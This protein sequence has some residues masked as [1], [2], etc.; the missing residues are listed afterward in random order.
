MR[1]I[2]VL[3]VPPCPEGSD[4]TLFSHLS[5]TNSYETNPA[6]GAPAVG[7]SC[8]VDRMLGES[9]RGGRGASRC[10]GRDCRP[11]RR[12]AGADPFDGRGGD[13][14]SELLPL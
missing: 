8:D 10:G 13:R 3:R 6:T 5:N 7:P 2:P 9:D 12:D 4:G 11:S 1:L 14:R